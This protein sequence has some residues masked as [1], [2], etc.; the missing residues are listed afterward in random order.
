MEK[1]N[2]RSIHGKELV[3]RG[4]RWKFTLDD[5]RFTGEPIVRVRWGPMNTKD[6]KHFQEIVIND[7]ILLPFI[8][9]LKR[10]QTEFRQGKNRGK[11]PESE[12]PPGRVA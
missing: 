12:G 3:H 11:K 1:R 9:N 2:K 4:F 5:I 7:R 10:A 6:P 8:R